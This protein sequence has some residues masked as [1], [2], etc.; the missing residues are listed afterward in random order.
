M[1]YAIAIGL[2]GILAASTIPAPAGAV[3]TDIHINGQPHECTFKLQRGSKTE[4]VKTDT[5]G[6][7]RVDLTSN[8]TVT[9]TTKN[10]D[11]APVP[12]TSTVP[13]S[14]STFEIPVQPSAP[15]VQTPSGFGSFAFAP[16]YDGDY[17]RHMK[18]TKEVDFTGSQSVSGNTKNGPKTNFN[19]NAGSVDIPIGLPPI[20]LFNGTYVFLAPMFDVGAATFNLNFTDK[21]NGDSVNYNGSG[22]VIGGGFDS[23]FMGSNCPFYGGL[24]MLYRTNFNPGVSPSPSFSNDAQKADLSFYQWH[25]EARIGYDVATELAVVRSIAPW[26]GLGFDSTNLTLKTSG[27][28]GG[29]PFGS[30]TDIASNDVRGMFGLDSHLAGPVWSRMQAS[31]NDRDFAF[32][33]KLVYQ[34]DVCDWFDH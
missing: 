1:K 8:E 19:M 6:H 34:F 33:A 27:M 5:T 21:K 12:V 17:L 13:A 2:A 14:G 28:S 4:T 10:N 3:A 23:T 26:A 7:A 31:F 15:M 24:G 30:E 25:A 11:Y 20:R 22:A 9:V 32:T 16:R 29:T 18:I